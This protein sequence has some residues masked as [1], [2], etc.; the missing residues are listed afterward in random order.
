MTLPPCNLSLTGLLQGSGCEC[1]M[2]NIMMIIGM[3]IM[4]KIL[5][6]GGMMVIKNGKFKKP[7]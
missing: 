4:M 6:L 3:M 7:K 5:F 1:G 2:V